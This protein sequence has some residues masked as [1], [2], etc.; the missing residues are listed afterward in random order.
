[1]DYLERFFTTFKVD[2]IFD[3]GAHDGGYAERIRRVGFTGPIVSFEPIPRIAARLRTRAASDPQWFIEEVALDEVAR[4][5]TFNVMSGLECSSLLE[6]DNS[7][8][9]LFAS[10]TRTVETLNIQTGVLET[11]FEKYSQKLGFSRP[12]LKMDTQ[13]ADVA[14]AK[15]AG[16]RLIDF[17]GLQSELAFKRLYRNQNTYREAIDFYEKHGFALTA[18]VPNNAGYFPALFELDC[19]MYNTRRLEGA[20]ET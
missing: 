7:E 12:F 19:I 16:P 1:L 10:G 13:G 15:G 4:P 3:V 9:K 8:T 6:P 17:V 11:F 20:S 2:C 14:V 18:L 5:V